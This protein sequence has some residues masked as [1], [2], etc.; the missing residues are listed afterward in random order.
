M[1][2]FQIIRER[3]WKEVTAVFNFPSTAT[4]ASF[5]LRKYYVSLLHHYEQLYF[6][7]ARG[8]VP[9]SSG[10]FI[11][12]PALA[13]TIIIKNSIS[14]KPIFARFFD[15]SIHTSGSN[16]ENRIF[17][18]NTRNPSGRPPSTKDNCF[19]ID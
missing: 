13:S 18:A 15:E 6:F 14:D 11:R 8:W 12:Q 5:V 7:K 19:R 4:N 3:R 10:V 16:S 1:D 2:F 9:M 17:A